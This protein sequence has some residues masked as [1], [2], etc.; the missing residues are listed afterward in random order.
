MASTQEH[1]NFATF[2]S[3]HGTTV[4]DPLL[5]RYAESYDSFTQF[6]LNIPYISTDKAFIQWMQQQ[7]I[8]N[9]TNTYLNETPVYPYQTTAPIN[10]EPVVVSTTSTS[11]TS[12]LE[13]SNANDNVTNQ[14][15]SEY[16]DDDI[17]HIINLD[18][19]LLEQPTK[20]IASPDSPTL[21]TS[22]F[23]ST[24]SSPPPPELRSFPTLPPPSSS[25]P[26]PYTSTTMETPLPIARK[27]LNIIKEHQT[28]EKKKRKRVANIIPQQQ[29]EQKKRK[30]GRPST[31]E[32]LTRIANDEIN[33]DQISSQELILLAMDGSEKKKKTILTCSTKN[34]ELFYLKQYT[35]Y[36][37]IG[38]AR[39]KAL[40]IVREQKTI[41][42]NLLNIEK[43]IAQGIELSKK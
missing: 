29:K 18:P 25:P 1:M 12:V 34:I 2:L 38:E 33:T 6:R 30:S 39:K 41:L 10:I 5:Y 17:Q 43:M 42:E 21:S 7:Q 14:L 9:Q 32:T 19:T 22:S 20:S 40:D 26:P 13:S 23:L 28:A 4:A 11:T 27:D 31:Q 37:Y 35:S 16:L 8:H 36:N 24:S 3:Y 15:V